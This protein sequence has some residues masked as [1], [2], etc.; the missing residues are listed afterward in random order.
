MLLSAREQRWAR[1]IGRAMIPPQTLG[2]A[3]GDIDFG[4]EMARHIAAAP[5]WSALAL[6]ASLWLVWLS[7]VLLRARP[8]L[9]G[10]LD[11]AGREALLEALL[12]SPVYPVRQ[13][14][15]FLKLVLCML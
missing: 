11:E 2:G 3:R 5:P 13:A 8:R 10:S 15:D 4:V 12:A 6:R 14:V 1:V 9:F 7:P